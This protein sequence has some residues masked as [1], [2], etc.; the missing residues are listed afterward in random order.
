[1]HRASF[2]R[3][4]YVITRNGRERTL[5]LWRHGDWRISDA[6]RGVSYPTCFSS[7]FNARRTQFQSL[8]RRHWPHAF[9]AR[10]QQSGARGTS[11][12]LDF[13]NIS[14]IFV[15]RWRAV[16][17]HNNVENGLRR[18]LLERASNSPDW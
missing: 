6:L 11:S 2:S 1:M 13:F 4:M 16:R 15:P 17:V 3:L 12:I 8:P 10:L 5:M 7:A 18:C 14:H 9:E